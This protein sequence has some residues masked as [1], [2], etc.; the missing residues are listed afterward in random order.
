MKTVSKL[1][2]RGG[3]SLNAGYIL[4]RSSKWFPHRYALFAGDRRLTYAQ[5]N[6][7]VNALAN[8]LLGLG[9]KKGD[10]VALLFHNSIAYVEFYLALYKAGLV[11]VRL[12]PRLSAREIAS[13]IVDC[14]AKAFVF[15]RGM[16]RLTEEVVASLPF[17]PVCI[18]ETGRRGIAYQAMLEQGPRREPDVDLNMDDISDLWYTSGTTGEPKGVVITHRNIVTC[19]QLLLG[20]VYHIT[21]RHRLLTSGALSHAGSVRMLA[22]WLRG[23]TNIVL[24]KFDP[25]EIFRIT[26]REGVTDIST[27]PTML[28][29][30][31]DEPSRTRYDLSSID[32]ITYA[33]APMPVSRIKEALGIFG[34][35]LSQS[36]GQ[37]ES[38][39]TITHLAKHEHVLDGGEKEGRLASVG[40]EYPGVVVKIVNDGKECGPGETGEV[41]TRSDLVMKGYWNKPEKTAETIRDGWL[42]TGD[43]GYKDEAGYLYLVDRANDKIISGGLN[44]YPREV[45]EVL[46]AH[47]AVAEV[48]VFGTAHPRWGEAISAAVV[49]RENMAVSADQLQAFCNGKLGRYK[50]PKRIFFCE[51]LPKNPYGKVLRRSLKEIYERE[52]GEE[53]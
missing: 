46:A 4:T 31:M 47:P 2:L 43:I 28:I 44:V 16:E 3:I 6:Q 39:I 21:P 9:L 13:I 48:A 15:G 22:F 10:R 26:E 53:K 1:G 19:V 30:L 25:E 11:W 36:Y 38:I 24:P 49:P 23:A 29:A 17:S 12:N 18:D 40:R 35:V 5:L 42:Y 37:A 20:E 51:K 7:D 45:E 41:V 27:V 50:I 52:G 33:G 32:T 34:Q 8:A 14:Q